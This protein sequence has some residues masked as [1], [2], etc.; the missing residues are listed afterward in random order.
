MSNTTELI[1][2]KKCLGELETALKGLDRD[3]VYFLYQQGFLTDD[4]LDEILKPKSTWTG[5]E[6]AGELVKSI[7]HGV[8]QDQQR[9]HSLVDWLKEREHFRPIVRVLEG[10]YCKQQQLVCVARAPSPSLQLQQQLDR[11]YMSCHT[12][13]MGVEIYRIQSNYS[14]RKIFQIWLEQ[15]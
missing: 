1:T 15:F 6:K 3:L 2:I 4:T 9:Y 10:E 8:E 12:D 14:T 5:A 13:H 11:K 7:K